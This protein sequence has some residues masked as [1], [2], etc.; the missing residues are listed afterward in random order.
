MIDAGK[1]RPLAV[2]A[3]KRE[4]LYPDVPTLKESIGSDWRI[5]VWRGI[6]GPKGLPDDVVSK[7]EVALDKVNHSQEFKDFMQKRG[8]GIGYASGAEYGAYMK[9]SMDDF[10]EVI[11]AIGMA[12]PAPN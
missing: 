6:A 12:R 4:P 2:M 11:T 8:F 1:A 9:K 5:G 7:M 10:G 3:D